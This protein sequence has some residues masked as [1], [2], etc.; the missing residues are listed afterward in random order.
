MLAQQIMAAWR[1]GI[2]S[3]YD[4]NRSGVLRA[5]CLCKHQERNGIASDYDG[6]PVWG[7]TDGLVPLISIGSLGSGRAQ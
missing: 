1:N 3:D 4:S 7:S 2:A 6:E 5:A